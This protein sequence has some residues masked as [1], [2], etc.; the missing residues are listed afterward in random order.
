MKPRVTILL[1]LGTSLF[2][3]QVL[4]RAWD[5]M[6]RDGATGAA[7]GCLFGGCKTKNV[8]RGAAAAVVALPTRRRALG[9]EPP[10]G[11]SNGP[12]FGSPCERFPSGTVQRDRCEDGA[13]RARQRNYEESVQQAERDG[14]CAVRP[15]DCGFRSRP[16][17][18]WAVR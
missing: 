6:V 18:Y 2:F 15:H 17:L 10:Y 14:Y 4:A 1:V 16:R 9:A 11:P 3:G 5:P 12:S 7:L 13:A 8:A